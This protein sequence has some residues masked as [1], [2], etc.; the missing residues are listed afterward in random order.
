MSESANFTLQEK[1]DALL[2]ALTT[3]AISQAQYDLQY[4]ILTNPTEVFSWGKFFSGIF[5]VLNPVDWAKDFASLF[6][7]RRLVIIGLIA[8][9]FWFGLHN[10]IP[11]FHFGPNSLNGKSF[12]INLGN[13]ENL[14]LNSSGQLQVVDSKT[15]KV[16]KTIRVKDIPELNKAINPIGFQLKPIAVV[17][18]GVGTTQG[19]GVEGGAGVSWFRLYNLETDSFVT[20]KGVYPLGISYRLN[21]FAGGNSSI[22]IAPG[23]GFHNGDKRILVYWRFTF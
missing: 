14:V 7:I 13:G 10:R 4:K 21:K 18:A 16:D 5:S 19:F 20:N 1:L 2:A 9:A 12:S 23:L 6:N 22:G 8:G 17:G 15:G 3:G 11:T